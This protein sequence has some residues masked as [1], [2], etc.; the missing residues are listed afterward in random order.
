MATA[1]GVAPA[2]AYVDVI[3]RPDATRMMS[4]GG[5]V[6]AGRTCDDLLEAVA[7]AIA[8]HEARWSSPRDGARVG[9]EFVR[10]MLDGKVTLG[11][12]AL[13]NLW[14]DH[15]PFSSCAAVPVADFG[16]AVS[17]AE[18]YY[19][20]NMG[21]GYNLDEFPDPLATLVALN[22]HAA[23]VEESAR[24]ER[25]VGNMAHLSVGHPQLR[26]FIEFKTARELRHF[27][28]SVNFSLTQLDR[29]LAGDPE[30]RAVLDAISE[31]AWSCGDPGIICLDRFNRGNPFRLH[32]PYSTTA[33]C[34]EVGLAPGDTCVFGY[35]NLAAF[36]PTTHPDDY[37][38]A[39]LRS[40]V[41]LVV[42]ALDDLL[43]ANERHLAD[44]VSRSLVTSKRRIG[45]SVCGYADLLVWYGLEYGGHGA[46]ALLED[47]LSVVN[48]EAVATSI[49][50]AEQRGSFASF[51]ISDW[52]AGRHHRPPPTRLVRSADWFRLHQRAR[53]RGLRHSSVTSLP[54]SGRSSILLAVNPSI[55]PFLADPRSTAL[56]PALR[57]HAQH[58]PD[59]VVRC[60]TDIGWRSHLDVVRAAAGLVDESVSKTVNLAPD[61]GVDDVR[62]VFL[63]FLQA[64]IK[65][66]SVYRP[67]A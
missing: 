28:L 33:P 4:A 19:L 41:A 40:A 6:P 25:Y 2:T 59:L 14:S 66:V 55:E 29:L 13:S 21:S 61:T 50:L 30:M 32:S 46:V 56:T 22:A 7:R 39:G 62:S 63:G 3:R 36:A 47:L 45:V 24:C 20:D 53:T 16:G 18:P 37:D 8:R 1:L 31:A 35:V 12:P 11:T 17:A 27:N 43:D 44:P 38:L 15:R 23:A 48:Y 49:A 51:P 64:D 54:P 26:D 10:A 67:S 5:I 65:A 57:A 34:A 60:A 58:Q 9:D 42:R 52:S